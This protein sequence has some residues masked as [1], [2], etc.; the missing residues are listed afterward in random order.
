[1][2]NTS[3]TEP[4]LLMNTSWVLLKNI[5]ESDVLQRFNNHWLYQMTF[6]PLCVASFGKSD[7]FLPPFLFTPV[8]LHPNFRKNL[9]LLRF[10][11]WS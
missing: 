2:A 4:F 8:P 10:I 9:I 3:I 11:S 6:Y 1:M 7:S 5:S